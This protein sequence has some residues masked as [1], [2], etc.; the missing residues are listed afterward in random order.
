MT[1][2]NNS[3]EG[4]FMGVSMPEPRHYPFASPEVVRELEACRWS[5]Y[6]EQRQKALAALGGV[7]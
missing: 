4:E 1:E 5:Y 3:R 6:R 7:A 2:H